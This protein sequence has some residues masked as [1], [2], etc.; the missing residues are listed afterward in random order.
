MVFYSTEIFENILVFNH[1][2]YAQYGTIAIAGLQ[3]VM[4]FVCMAVIDKCGRKILLLIG[5]IGMCIFSLGIAIFLIINEASKVN[6][7]LIFL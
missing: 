4:T 1:G 3:V 6:N 5:T 7:F 2:S